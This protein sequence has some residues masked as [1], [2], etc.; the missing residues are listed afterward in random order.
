MVYSD[1]SA[2][3][4][5]VT[6]QLKASLQVLVKGYHFEP[7]V[8]EVGAYHGDVSATAVEVTYRCNLCQN[9]KPSVQVQMKVC[10]FK[11]SAYEVETYQNLGHYNPSV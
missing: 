1:V 2:S 9:L 6:N 8:Y 3:A 11:P 10:H 5:E 7:S 4:L